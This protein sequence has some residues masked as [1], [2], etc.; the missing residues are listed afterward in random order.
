[1]PITIK[2]VAFKAGVSTATVSRTFSHPDTV[3]PETRDKVIA[4]ANTLGFNIP[5]SP[6]PLTADL[7]HRHTHRRAE[8]HMV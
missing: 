4:A 3:R 1:M 6:Q 5:S 8:R 2:D 7:S